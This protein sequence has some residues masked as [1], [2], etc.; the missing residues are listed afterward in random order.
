MRNDR[1]QLSNPFSTGGGGHHFEAHVQA[2]FVTLML[3]GGHAPCLPTWPIK[4]LNLQTKVDDNS[5]DD[6]MVTVEN[7]DSKVIRKLIAQVKHKIS[8]TKGDDLFGEVIQAAWNDFNKSSR[9][10]KDGPHLA[11]ITGQSSAISDA[12][13]ILNQARHTTNAGEFLKRVQRTNF[14]SNEKRKKLKA[15]QCQLKRANDDCQVTNDELY[16]FLQRFYLV[17]YDLGGET[18]GTLPLLTSHMSQFTDNPLWAWG[19]IVDI[20]QTR[21]QDAGTIT[22]DNL[23]DDILEIFESPSPGE[24]ASDASTRQLSSPEP[25]WNQLPF[26]SDL[27]L[28]NL[29][30][31]WNENNEADLEIIRK[32]TNK[33]SAVW[34]Q[35]VRESLYIS[36]R[37]LSLQ[38][39]RWQVVDRKSLWQSLGDR[40]FDS[41]LADLEEAAV[42]VL[43]ER[44]PKFDLPAQDRYAAQVYG[45]VP[46]HSYDLRNGLAE[47]LALLGNR[48]SSLKYCSQHR[49]ENV[50]VIA[51][52]RIL[53][54]ADWVIWGSLDS[55]LPTLAEA[56]PVEFLKAIECGLQQDPCPFDHLFLQEKAG[57]LGGNYHTGLLRALETLAWEEEYLVSAC[58]ML[59]ALASRDPG[60]NST[61]RPANSLKRILHPHKPQTNAPY[62]KQVIAVN[63]LR[64][65]YP[66]VAWSL[67]LGSFPGQMDI[68]LPT[69]RPKWRNSELKDRSET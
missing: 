26:A 47:S 31:A 16:M 33:E 49:P 3:A 59:G 58:E 8:I 68:L 18:G 20:V 23:P 57:A 14:S 24:S 36:S 35:S 66:E 44:D 34:L 53:H 37:P 28:A 30:G 7:P 6:L 56:S 29:L 45:A 21:N 42:S 17:Q 52:R 50:A 48:H 27:V 51:I 55:R 10:D 67:F 63:M 11:L 46:S 32:F 43:S 25:D 40:V 1:K 13:W 9:F 5:L 64:Q 4:E 12:V 38:N 62:E 69:R 61:S 54:S 60:G 41:N 15:F 22:R 39:G 2:M 65:E 19:R